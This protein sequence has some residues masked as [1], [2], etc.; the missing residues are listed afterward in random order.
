MKM[1]VP[2]IIHFSM[3]LFQA[4][5]SLVSVSVLAQESE[6]YPENVY[7]GDLHVHT[8]NSLDAY[9]IGTRATPEA[10]L[11]FA[12]GFP[13]ETLNGPPTSLRVPL[14]FVALTD[15]AEFFGIMARVN[16][17][18]AQLYFQELQ[19]RINEHIEEQGPSCPCGI[20][21]SVPGVRLTRT[22]PSQQGAALLWADE[23]EAVNR[24]NE[25]PNFTAFVAYEWTSGLQSNLHRNVIF[26]GH[27]PR[28]PWDAFR[29]DTPEELWEQMS[30]FRASGANGSDSI[31]IPHN[32]NLSGGLMYS[33]VMSDGQPVDSQ[34]AIDRS[35]NEPLAEIIQTK[36]ASETH[37][38]LSSDEDDDFEL[39]PAGQVLFGQP[40]D[41]NTTATSYLRE[42]FKL[43]LAHEANL[44]VNP[45]KQGVV[46]ATDTHN[47]TP[48]RTEETSY[49]GHHGVLTTRRRID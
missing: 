36:G 19:L 2:S 48:G 43:G 32:A 45:F 49:T 47:G 13:I 17:P 8:A 35:F 37:T 14:D 10:A 28:L 6:P 12:R 33:P 15:H 26:E 27:G 20:L 39:Q 34:Y 4:T 42:A 24:H 30:A 9:V 46:G 31:A 40:A 1:K 29:Y 18:G 21:Q 41:P 7:F 23:M 11:R 22:F 3:I 25:A 5:V 44:G 38:V 16:D